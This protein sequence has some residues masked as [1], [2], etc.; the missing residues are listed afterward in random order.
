VGVKRRLLDLCLAQTLFLAALPMR[1]V[2]R[3]SLP[4]MPRAYGALRKAGV[5]PILDH[6]YEPLFNTQ[7]LSALDQPRPL[8]AIELNLI[9]QVRLLESFDDIAGLT[10]GP[11]DL[12]INPNFGSGDAELWFHVIRHFKPRRIYEIGSGYSTL[13]ALR[14]IRRNNDLDP[15]YS[16]EHVCIEPYEMAWLE[17]TSVQILRKKVE[18]VDLSIFDNL[19]E[20]DVL[21]IDS[22]HMI[23]P[24]GDVLREYLQIIPRLSKGVIVHIHD[25]FTPRDYTTYFYNI[26]RF[27]NEQY[28]LEA[29]LANNRFWEVLL[30]A[31]MLKHEHFDL[32]KSKCIW[33]TADREPGSFYMRRA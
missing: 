17:D 6:Y 15:D 25:I 3:Y 16:C 10:S 30:A 26:P 24:Q 1:F 29:F 27:W 19:S 33:L 20:N 11:D 8:P 21:F 9:A 31:N 13:V 32:M 23:R 5:F 7:G 28:L 12:A 4:E 22:S 18:D 14:A 2:R